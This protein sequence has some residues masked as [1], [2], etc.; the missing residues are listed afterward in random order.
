MQ[1]PV[2]GPTLRRLGVGPGTGCG[3]RARGSAHPTLPAATDSLHGVTEP[4]AR[5][6][7]TW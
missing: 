5:T 2:P 1:D 3:S 7:R 6:P 4:S